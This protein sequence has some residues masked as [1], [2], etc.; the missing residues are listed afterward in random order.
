MPHCSRVLRLTL[1]FW[2]LALAAGCRTGTTKGPADQLLADGK[3]YYEKKEYKQAI[4]RF[5]GVNVYHEE[6]EQA[7]EALFLLAESARHLR[8]PGESLEAYEKLAERYPN[9]RFAVGAAM[10][11][12]QLGMDHFEGKMPGFLFIPADRASG[13]KVLEHMQVHYRNHS[14]ADDALMQ[15]ADFQMGEE[16]YEDAAYRSGTSRS[17]TITTRTRSTPCGACSPSTR[18]PS[19][20]SARATSSLDACGTR[21]AAPS[22]TS[23]CCATRAA[24]SRTSSGPSSWTGSRTSTPTRS[25]PRKR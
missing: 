18:A 22:T 23:S 13:I 15:V 16:E 7:E 4:R 8:Y 5:R 9:S 10:G 12:Y 19:T 6:S 3:G 25:S 2:L 20:P 21:T 24:R 1:P 11:E 17:A 14:L